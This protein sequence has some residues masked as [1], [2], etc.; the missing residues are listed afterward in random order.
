MAT[1]GAVSACLVASACNQAPKGSA[2]ANHN[3]SDASARLTHLGPFGIDMG[4]PLAS[5]G[6]TEALGMPAWY[7]VTSPPNPSP[8]FT[9][10][11]VEAFPSTGVCQVSSGG[12]EVTGDATGAAM[13]GQIDSVADALTSKYGKPTKIDD[14]SSGPICGSEFWT[15]A[16]SQGDRRYGYRWDDIPNSR[17]SGVGR[18]VLGVKAKDLTSSMVIGYFSKRAA[19]C[20]KA[21][22]AAKAASL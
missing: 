18:I 16:I 1:C 19:L 14:C 20:K 3:S 21:E 5:V 17:G 8:D 2:A 12:P 4:E 9:T 13:T 15:M 11:D 22:N 10:V 6:P 7:H